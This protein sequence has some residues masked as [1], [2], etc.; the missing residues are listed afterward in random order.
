MM[1]INGEYY[2]QGRVVICISN[3]YTVLKD[4]AYTALINYSL[5]GTAQ[6]LSEEKTNQYSFVGIVPSFTRASLSSSCTHRV[7]HSGNASV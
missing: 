2:S 4:I 5:Y 7:L 3:L 6:L 1:F